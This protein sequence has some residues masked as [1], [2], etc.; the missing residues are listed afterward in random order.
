MPI[1]SA[2]SIVEE[3][4]PDIQLKMPT[5]SVDNTYQNVPDPLPKQSMF[6]AFI[7]APRSGKSSLATAL[8]T[9][10]SP[11]K[12]YNGV[13]DDVYLIVPLASYNSMNNNPF[14]S[15]HPSKR[16]HEFNKEILDG[17]VEKLEV[18]SKKKQL[19]LII[20]DDYMSELKNMDLRKSLERLVANRRH[21][22]CSVWVI[23]QTYIAIPL[24]TRKMLSDVVMF[25]SN[26]MKELE[27]LR[28]ELVPIDRHIFMNVY[29]HIF[30]EG[31]DKHTFL[32]LKTE[33]GEMYKRWT[34]LRIQN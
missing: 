7:G 33:T 24:S 9:T 8:L 19:S 6:M 3:E 21:L 1:L 14:N 25:R 28:Q 13:F 11:K 27:S 32:Y 10:S 15:L 22:L 5:F 26:N 17:I 16:I 31:G 30:P 12:V 34:K 29:N 2:M 23:S 20:I 4:E 18:A